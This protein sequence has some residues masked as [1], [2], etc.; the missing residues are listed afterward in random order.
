M[1]LGN[2]LNLLGPQSLHLENGHSIRYAWA[3]LL[4]AEAE[5]STWGPVCK[6][7]LFLLP[8]FHI[9]SGCPDPQAYAQSIA[10]A[11]VVF[12]MGAELSLGH[13]SWTS[14]A[15][16]LEDA[17]VKIRRGKWGHRRVLSTGL[18]G[19]WGVIVILGSPL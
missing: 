3:R 18:G 9:G 6:L 11:R 10:D 17:K 7:R 15:A 5:V 13:T 2:P 4:L 19:G 14:V 12:E 1:A 16:S 8:Q